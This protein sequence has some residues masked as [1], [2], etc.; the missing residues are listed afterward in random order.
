M[1]RLFILSRHLFC[2]Y[3]SKSVRH[4]CDEV[5]AL[6]IFAF[7]LLSHRLFSL[8]RLRVFCMCAATTSYL[9]LMMFSSRKLVT[10]SLAYILRVPFLLK[11]ILMTWNIVAHAEPNC[12]ELTYTSRQTTFK[13]TSKALDIATN[14]TFSL[15]SKEKKLNSMRVMQ[16]PYLR[17][18]NLL[19][20][21]KA[22]LINS[23]WA[24]SHLA[25]VKIW[26]NDVS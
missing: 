26:L 23:P 1:S 3:K 5:F 11:K 20:N 21:A 17:E 18:L 22:S 10:S 7:S 12:R 13:L 25:S 16:V 8:E 2:V 6:G 4:H 15:V 19:V 14:V 9:S 24:V